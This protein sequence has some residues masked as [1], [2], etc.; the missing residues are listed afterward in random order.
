[1]KN[2]SRCESGANLAGKFCVNAIASI[3][4]AKLSKN[5]PMFLQSSRFVLKSRIGSRAGTGSRDKIFR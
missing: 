2:E 5:A 3:V 4:R 1:M